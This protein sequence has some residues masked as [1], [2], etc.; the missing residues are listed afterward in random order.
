MAIGNYERLNLASGPRRLSTHVDSLAISAGVAEKFTVPALATIVRLSCSVDC[1]INGR[2]TAAV[3]TDVTDGSAS[4]L[5]RAGE[6]EL[7]VTPAQ[8]I[9]VISASNGLVTA[10]FYIQ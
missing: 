5:V 9:S 2:G 8:E 4:E 6:V 7:L 1:Y 3:A 10:A